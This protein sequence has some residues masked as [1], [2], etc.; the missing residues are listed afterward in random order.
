[1]KAFNISGVQFE[2]VQRESC[3]RLVQIGKGLPVTCAC[4]AC[5]SRKPT[6]A[7]LRTAAYEAEQAK[8]YRRAAELYQAAL[9]A[10]PYRDPK[11]QLANADREGLNRRARSMRTMVVNTERLCEVEA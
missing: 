6:T 11:N 1:M 9:D 8:D 5:A 2:V 7:Q 3:Y 4:S 10:Y